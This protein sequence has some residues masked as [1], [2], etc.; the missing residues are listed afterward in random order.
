M[1]LLLSLIQQVFP[2]HQNQ[3]RNTILV[4]LM[5]QHQFCGQE[6]NIAEMKEKI[7]YRDIDIEFKDKL[8]ESE[9]VK[10][11]NFKKEIKER[12]CLI[13]ELNQQIVSQ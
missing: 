12:D 11:T 1:V 3:N 9:Y 13:A 2:E 7:E 8:L 5:V 10:N 4:N 6:E